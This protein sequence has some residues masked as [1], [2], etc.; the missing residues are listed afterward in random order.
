MTRRS[1]AGTVMRSG[2]YRI[3]SATTWTEVVCP[4]GGTA[5]PTGDV[6]GSVPRSSTTPTST[7]ARTRATPAATPRQGV[8]GGSAPG[9]RVPAP[10]GGAPA[11]AG[12][13]AVPGG[14][15]PASGDGVPA[16]GVGSGD[17]S[18][19]VTSGW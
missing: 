10:V 1:P 15:A 18:G 16:A 17:G 7:A 13:A 19:T 14:G 2:W 4:V 6:S 8:G 5:A 9:P 3:P 12:G 11:P